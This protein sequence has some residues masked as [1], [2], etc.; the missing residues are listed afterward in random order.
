MTLTPEIIKIAQRYLNL[1]NLNAG[2]VDGVPGNKTYAALNNLPGLTKS[3]PPERK[4]VGAVQLFAKEEGLDPGPIDGLWG[5]Q[6]QT[7]YD[8]LRHILLY[9]QAPEPWRPEDRTPVN[10]NNWPL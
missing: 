3:W 7:A 9:G 8:E 4:I 5:A 1:K 10:P 6:T 2:A